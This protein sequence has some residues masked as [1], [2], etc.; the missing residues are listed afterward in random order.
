MTAAVLET[1]HG[2]QGM[3]GPRRHAV[4]LAGCAVAVALTTIAVQLLK[5]VVAVISLH[6]IAPQEFTDEHVR[7]VAAVAPS[8]AVRLVPS[9][10]RYRG[11]MVRSE[12]C[13]GGHILACAHPG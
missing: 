1:L 3:R 4:A 5:S 10:W 8:W 6:T 12:A 9:T 13:G 11:A 2:V 7:L